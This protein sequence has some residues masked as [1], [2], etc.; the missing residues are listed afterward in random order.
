[1]T[2]RKRKGQ[3][4]KDFDHVGLG[5]DDDAETSDGVQIMRTAAGRG[6]V[7]PRSLRGLKGQAAEVVSELQRT[8]VAIGQA[9]DDLGHLVAEARAHG[10]SWA[11]IGWSVGTSGEA[12]RQRWGGGE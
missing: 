2:P 9:Q 10:V 11:G 3:E 7:L 4:S 5:N 8:A 1:M 12:A 6:V